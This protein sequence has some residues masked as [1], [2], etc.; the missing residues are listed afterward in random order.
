MILE[1]HLMKNLGEIFSI[2]IG[3]N[4]LA[5]K[6]SEHWP[7]NNLVRLVENLTRRGV[8]SIFAPKDGI[9]QEWI[10]SV[11]VTNSRICDSQELLDYRYLIIENEKEQELY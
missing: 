11:V 2:T 4:L 3:I 1:T 9:V 10:T 6:I 8:A 5:P 7:Q